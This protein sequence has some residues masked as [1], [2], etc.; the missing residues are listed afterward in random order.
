MESPGIAFITGASYGL[1]FGH[2]R[3][4]LTLSDALGRRQIAASFALH[5]VDDSVASWMADRETAFVPVS[6]RDASDT[7]RFC[8]DK[9]ANVVVVD[10]YEARAP[11]L[12]A[13]LHA[14]CRVLVVDDLADRSLPATWATSSAVAPD[15]TIY[16]ERTDA[17]LLL[18]PAYAILRPEFA[19]LAK[20][21]HPLEVRRVL[22]TMGGSDA[23]NCTPGVLRALNAIGADLEVSVVLGPLVRCVDECDSLIL[24]SHHRVEILRSVTDMASLMR[25]ADLAVSAAGQT[26]FELAAAGCPCVGV[27]VAGNQAFTGDLFSGIGAAEILPGFDERALSDAVSKLLA[28]RVRRDRMSRAGQAA[29]DGRGA[30]RLADLLR[31]AVRL[32]PGAVGR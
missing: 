12:S 3:R 22:V 14:G 15:S 29:V 18:G 1:G 6:I 17:E 9:N 24:Q 25:W 13:L 11:F 2:L 10:S 31:D 23:A 26:L 27:Q 5:E 32:V 30:D 19:A 8:R 7:L 16:V 28:D 4:C 20:K 21:D